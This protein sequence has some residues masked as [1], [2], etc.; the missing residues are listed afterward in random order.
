MNMHF[1]PAPLALMLV[2]LAGSAVSPVW[3]A[4]TPTTAAV[5]GSAPVLS[6]P[7]NDAAGAVD[8]SG[9][10][11]TSGALTTGDTLVMTYIY[12]DSDGDLDA[13]LTTVLWAYFDRTSGQAVTIVAANVPAT[14]SGGVGTS[15][16]VI[17]AGATG[18]AA[19][20][21]TL[22]AYSVTG[23]P[24]SGSTLTVADTSAGGGGTVTPPG[25]V[26]PGGNLVGGIFLQLDNP[27][28][29]GG[30]VD[31]TRSTARP[32]VGAIY[33]FYAWDDTNNNKV[34]DAGEA[35]L[36]AT[37]NSI[38]WL[39]DGTNTSAS[40]SS[41]PSTLSDHPIA[42]ANGVTYTVRGSSDSSSGAP[43]GDQGFSLKVDFN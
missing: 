1:T 3:A 8:F 2:A 12:T 6:A 17:P 24:I 15:T 38:Q 39:L 41:N 43:S 9:T 33:K 25:P 19:I 4:S 28:A 37:L 11:A 13:S 18:A 16:I 34:W 27:T 14:A 42:N 30:A 21:V 10:Y 31:Y 5:E 20:S 26:V 29:G 35:D 22:Q 7:S 36:T 32:Q 40:G 23:D